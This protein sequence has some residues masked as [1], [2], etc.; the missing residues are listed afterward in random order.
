M[1][2]LFIPID[3]NGETLNWP[4]HTVTVNG[5]TKT[6][7]HARQNG[8]V[9]EAYVEGDPVLL[10][11]EMETLDQ[12][13]NRALS[14]LAD[15]RWSI[16][17]GGCVWNGM[18]IKTDENSMTKILGAYVDSQKDPANWS[19]NWKTAGIG[20]NGSPLWAT[21]DASII[22][23]IYTATREH[24][25]ICFNV[26]KDKQ[27]EIMSLSTNEEVNEW[28]DTQLIVGWPT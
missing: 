9:F 5:E 18:T 14:L 27:E 3:E 12:I 17:S 16:E 6:V 21:L 7:I 13:K 26:E 19:V 8:N 25:R 20:Q 23:A 1:G 28:L 22:D 15:Y 4:P 2:E 10:P 24:M 11:Q